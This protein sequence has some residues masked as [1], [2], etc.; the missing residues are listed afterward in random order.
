MRK[1]IFLFLTIMISFFCY[2]QEE[3]I[4]YKDSAAIIEKKQKAEILTNN[5]FINQYFGIQAELGVSKKQND[6]LLIL[7]YYSRNSKKLVIDPN[8]KF[9]LEFS[10][11][12]KI[13][14]SAQSECISDIAVFYDVTNSIIIAEY[15]C[16]KNV[17]EKLRQMR[18]VKTNIEFSDC[19]KSYRIK[20]KE[21][22][23][24]QEALSG[25][26]I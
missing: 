12:A 17:I 6:Y 2:A 8:N 21:A 7:K 15:N 23:K 25:I 10:D 3:I 5:Y 11:G 19:T 18:I 14:L 24:I 1:I 4:L 13:E 16:S 26:E 20:E 22:R 9:Q